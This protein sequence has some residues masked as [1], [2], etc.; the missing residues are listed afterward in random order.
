MDGT[1]QYNG[2]ELQLQLFDTSTKKDWGR[3]RRLAYRNTN[4]VLVC[5]SV[6]NRGSFDNVSA[7]WIKEIESTFSNETVP[8]V[9][10]IGL[11]TDKRVAEKKGGNCFVTEREGKRLAKNINALAYYECSAYDVDSVK[12]VFTSVIQSMHQPAERNT[13]CTLL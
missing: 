6:G 11:Q 5:F 7:L 8:P 1:L 9:F 2:Q 12:N 10:V 4:V 13:S 3:V